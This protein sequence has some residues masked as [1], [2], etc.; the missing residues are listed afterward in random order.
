MVKTYIYYSTQIKKHAHSSQKGKKII[1][2]FNICTDIA[3]KCLFECNSTLW[4]Q[5]FFKKI[6]VLYTK[7]GAPIQTFPRL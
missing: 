7:A 2:V 5:K 1:S 6:Y 3:V 4:R